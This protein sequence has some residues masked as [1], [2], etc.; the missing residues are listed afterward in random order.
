MCIKIPPTSHKVTPKALFLKN[1][2][3]SFF[4]CRNERLSIYIMLTIKKVFAYEILVASTIFTYYVPHLGIYCSLAPIF[5]LLLSRITF[6]IDFCKRYFKI[7]IS[8]SCS[9]NQKFSHTKEL[10]KSCSYVKIFRY[11][12]RND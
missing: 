12:L 1:F 9:L 7:E 10:R 5:L 11:A 3:Y 2:V 4:T 8:S 6:S